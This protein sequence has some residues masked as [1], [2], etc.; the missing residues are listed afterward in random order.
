MFHRN[1]IFERQFSQ[2]LRD[3]R[4]PL[5]E[6]FLQWAAICGTVTTDNQGTQV[7]TPHPPKS[8]GNV[9]K[10]PSPIEV[11]EKYKKLDG[12]DKTL[13]KT[14]ITQMALMAYNPD[15]HEMHVQHSQS[16]YN[17]WRN[18]SEK[19]IPNLIGPKGERYK[20]DDH[21]QKGSYIAMADV[22]IVKEIQNFARHDAF[23]QDFEHGL[24]NLFNNLIPA[25]IVDTILQQNIGWYKELRR[26]GYLTSLQFMT[27]ARCP[28]EGTRR[29]PKIRISIHAY[30]NGETFDLEKAIKEENC[31]MCCGVL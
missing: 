4:I 21:H 2:N 3:A 9:P 26:Q 5:S 27:A 15:M 18:I 14:M 20:V 13:T 11:E 12:K 31:T 23:K 28:A 24:V 25:K 29:N 10:M 17:F 6:L 7:F 19:V 22:Q 30:D 8:F 16:Y 1:T